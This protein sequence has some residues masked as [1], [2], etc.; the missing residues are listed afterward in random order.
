MRHLTDGVE[1]VLGPG[2]VLSAIA[3]PMSIGSLQIFRS[4]TNAMWRLSGDQHVYTAPDESGSGFDVNSFRARR[5]NRPL[6]RYT[7]QRPSGDNVGAADPQMPRWTVARQTRSLNVAAPVSVRIDGNRTVVVC[8]R[9][10]SRRDVR[11]TDAQ[12]T[13]GSSRRAVQRIA[14]DSTLSGQ[15]PS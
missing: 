2:R 1:E 8:I 10:R 7:S 3:P 15:D 11:A 12:A 5:H 13:F 4:R 9:R 14:F 6:A